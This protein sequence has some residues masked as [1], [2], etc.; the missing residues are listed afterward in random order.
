MTKE[1]FN[2]LGKTLWDIADQL[3]GAMNA[4]DFCYSVCSNLSWRHSSADLRP[5]SWRH[6]IGRKRQS[7]E[8]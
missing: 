7:L 6:E 4:D 3:R 8:V 1:E 2:Q 5:I